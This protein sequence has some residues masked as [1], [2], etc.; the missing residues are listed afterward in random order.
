MPTP[1]G[2]TL[3]LAGP[4][5]LIA[6]PRPL[7]IMLELDAS[8][9]DWRALDLAVEIAALLSGELH[10][11]LI[12]NMD[13]LRVAGLPFAREIGI[14]SALDRGYGAELM[15]RSLRAAARHI[16]THLARSAKAANVRWSLQVIHRGPAPSPTAEELFDVMVLGPAREWHFRP[17]ASPVD[18]RLRLLWWGAGPGSPAGPMQA[19]LGLLAR[20]GQIEIFLL[21]GDNDAR[22]AWLRDMRVPSHRLGPG[23]D[24][25]Q[26]RGAL[27]AWRIRPSYCIAPRALGSVMLDAIAREIGCPVLVFGE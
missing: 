11:R 27:S 15:L 17:T 3:E 19:L 20:R 8:A 1:P 14:S 16:E 21:G 18:K 24:P 9:M 22:E 23:D 5:R 4:A 10:G 6:L 26:L 7:R 2:P 13:L 12:Q 25:R